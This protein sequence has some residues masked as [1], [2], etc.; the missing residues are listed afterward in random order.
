[1]T[2]PDIYEHLVELM[3]GIDV[4]RYRRFKSHRNTIWFE[5]YDKKQMI[6]TYISPSNYCLRT[7]E[8]ESL[9]NKEARR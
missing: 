7:V 1:M 4:E 5:T 6:F 8:Y 9:T 2:P 3:P